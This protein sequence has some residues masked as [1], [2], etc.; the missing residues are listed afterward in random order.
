[1]TEREIRENQ[2]IIKPRD[3]KRW[4]KY[5][6]KN[7]DR[8]KAYASYM[9]H[10]LP[11]TLIFTLSSKCDESHPA[12][13][14]WG[15]CSK[16]S[17]Y[18]LSPVSIYRK[19]GSCVP[20]S[21]PASRKPLCEAKAGDVKMGLENQYGFESKPKMALW[22]KVSP[23]QSQKMGLKCLAELVCLE[24]ESTSMQEGWRMSISQS[25]ETALWN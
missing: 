16:I 24:K 1:M 25:N 15:P 13:E 17:K 11:N 6:K 10:L 14:F 21:W 18:W 19:S 23:G 12:L 3:G 22:L 7:P 4:K 8:R 5:Y 9:V 2:Y 20:F